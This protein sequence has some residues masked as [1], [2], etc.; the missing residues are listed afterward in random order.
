[1]EMDWREVCLPNLESPNG[2][3]AR[4]M[5][6]NRILLANTVSTNLDTSKSNCRCRLR[7]AICP[8]FTCAERVKRVSA[9]R[10]SS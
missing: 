4:A 1:M 5:V 7:R 2:P 8:M 3:N 9:E 10:T 6:S